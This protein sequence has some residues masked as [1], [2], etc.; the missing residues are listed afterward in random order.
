MQE[1]A[2][3]ERKVFKF[4]HDGDDAKAAAA[5]LTRGFWELREYRLAPPKEGEE[6]AADAD[7]KHL[8]LCCVRRT[9]GEGCAWV[10]PRP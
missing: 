1:C 3:Y 9:D 8:V 4:K 5:A 6:G 2:G 10:A 7:A